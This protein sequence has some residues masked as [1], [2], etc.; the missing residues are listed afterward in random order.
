MAARVVPRANL[1]E[2]LA[3]LKTRGVTLSDEGIKLLAEKLE[4]EPIGKP[5]LERS[6]T[7]VQNQ[8]FTHVLDLVMVKRSERIQ[9][10][11]DDSP[12]LMLIEEK[13]K[14]I[15][16]DTPPETPMPD[17][18]RRVF[19]DESRWQPFFP[20]MFNPPEGQ[21][22]MVRE[23]ANPELPY[24]AF[25]RPEKGNNILY[26]TRRK[27]ALD[28]LPEAKFFRLKEGVFQYEI[29]EI[30][31]LEKGYFRYIMMFHK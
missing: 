22:L 18:L 4:N 30:K 3:F 12:L 11:A 25:T 16:K 9:K 29:D 1:D 31:N 2:V 20:F 6:K 17:S 5:T 15:K 14:S 19:F 7:I 10:I 27:T 8:L 13:R 21:I 26:T 23:L 24:I 28:T